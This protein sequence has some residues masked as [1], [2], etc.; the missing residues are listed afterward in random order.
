M[1]NDIAI[2][3][4][5]STLLILLLI[6]GVAISFFVAARERSKQQVLLGQTR[7]NYEKEL[8]QVETEVSEYMMQQFAHELHDNIGHILT[9]MKLAVENKKLDNPGD[10]GNYTLF[11]KYLDEGSQQLRLLSRSLNTDYVSSNGLLNA[12]QL[13][14]ERQQQLKKFQVHY[15]Q[16]GSGITLDKNQQLMTFRIFQEII[17]NS[18]KHSR[19]KNVY[20]T[21]HTTPQF[22]LDVV[23]DGT[24]FDVDGV[25]STP[26]SSG[27]KNIIKRAEMS[28][29][30]CT[31][32][33]TKDNGCSYKITENPT[34]PRA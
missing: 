14:I 22:E 3:I 18:I 7:L 29:L 2:G 16:S 21:I 34:V 4:I 12:I 28:N 9:C 24:G 5:L 17:Q 31:I 30:V 11:E 1:S 6:A 25:L 33:S 8:R 32:N 26:K 15:N 20:V 23:D 10:A 27:L 13:E 19:A